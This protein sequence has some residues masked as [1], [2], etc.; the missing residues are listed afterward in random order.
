LVQDFKIYFIGRCYFLFLEKP[1]ALDY[2]GGLI[3][4]CYAF[5]FLV[6][7]QNP[8]MDKKFWIMEA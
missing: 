3:C 4:L 5:A 8:D 6:S 2:F 7:A 1:I